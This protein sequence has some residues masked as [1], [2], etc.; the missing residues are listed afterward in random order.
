MFFMKKYFSEENVFIFQLFLQITLFFVSI[1]FFC[2]VFF[3][4]GGGV[5]MIFLSWALNYAYKICSNSWGHS[6]S[7]YAV[8]EEGRWGTPKTCENVQREGGGLPRVYVSPY[9]FKG[10]FPH[11]NRLFLF[12]TS[13]M[14]NWKLWHL[15]KLLVI[16]LLI[17]LPQDISI[18]TSRNAMFKCNLTITSFS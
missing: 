5:V 18:S 6:K 11:L 10:V 12:F 15:E 3:M 8:M 9:F 13:L 14:V 7:T 1:V 16:L 4:G 17:W 2:F